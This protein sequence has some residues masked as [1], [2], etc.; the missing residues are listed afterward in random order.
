MDSKNKVFNI[1]N[2]PKG[3]SAPHGEE[4]YTWE[5]LDENGKL[6]TDSKN[7]SEEI[8]SYLPMVDYKK[9]IA[10][11]E[12]ENGTMGFIPR[13]YSDLPDNTVDI[14][15]Y[16]SAL[17]NLSQEQIA[18]LLESVNKTAESVVQEEQ[19]PNQESSAGGEASE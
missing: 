7:V 6:Q 4:I 15:K 5:Y 19:V 8:N 12:L 10:R 18:K 3:K 1:F 16:V 11:G 13:D 9:Q 14:Y 2:A 17:A